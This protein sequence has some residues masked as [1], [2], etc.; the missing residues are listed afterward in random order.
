MLSGSRTSCNK[1]SGSLT[2][3]LT[4]FFNFNKIP[5]YVNEYKREF[6]FIRGLNKEFEYIINKLDKLNDGLFESNTVNRIKNY[7]EKIFT[8]TRKR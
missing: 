4:S 1:F 5:E 6:L 8:R 2:G 3:S 7:Y